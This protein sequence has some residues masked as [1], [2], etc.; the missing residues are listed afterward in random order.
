[1]VWAFDPRKLIEEEK[2][3]EENKVK[4]VLSDQEIF[5]KKVEE[6]NAKAEKLK[7]AEER[8][9][10]VATAFEEI[11]DILKEVNYAKKYGGKKYLEAKKE[12]DPD[13]PLFDT[14]TEKIK[15]I[16]E[17]FSNLG[18]A[19][20]TELSGEAKAYTL[21]ES[22]GDKEEK[23]EVEDKPSIFDD[24]NVNDVGIGQASMA[25]LISGTIKIGAGFFQFGAMVKDAFA[26]DG[27]PLDETNL[28]KFNEIFENSYIGQLGKHSEEIAR[29]RAIGRLTELGV[30]L[31]G[32][33]ST[34]GKL[35]IVV[36]NKMTGIFNKAVQAYKKG[37]Y[38][39]A[40]GNTNMYKAAKEIEKLNKLSGTQKFGGTMIGGGFGTAAVIYKAE[41]VGTIGDIFF[42]DGEWSAMQ[43]VKGKDGKAD[44]IRQLYNKLK[45]GAE[46]AVPIIPIIV[47]GGRIGKL[48]AQKSKIMAYSGNKF[49]Q[50]V[51]KYISK[52]LRARGQW[53]ANQFRAIQKM[54]GSKDAGKKI[55]EDYLKR[56]DRIIHTIEKNAFPAS[57]A[58]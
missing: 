1:M 11:K 50:F 46:L 5:D 38:I 14:P 30:Q 34:G 35:A 47:G 22:Q 19:I 37:K 33:W 8:K 57:R 16:K 58:S 18:S 21:A 10:T 12:E 3:K 53:E 40:T 56:F 43:R 32:G 2:K 13:H 36:A 54:E 20:E 15:A 4:E 55:A 24:P 49:E 48:I 9:G 51:E 45:L 26:E 39:K 6:E 31:Y 42:N 27:I 44:A 29:E 23:E 41:D 52:P 7:D 25:A 17:Q 28:A